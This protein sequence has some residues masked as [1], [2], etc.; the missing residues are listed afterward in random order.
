MVQM[1]DNS[2]LAITRVKFYLV[3]ENRNLF[4]V[5]PEAC[6]RGAL[7]YYLYDRV[8]DLRDWNQNI[9]ADKFE[10]L[11]ECL[12]GDF[13]DKKI[14]DR[15]ATLPRRG[16]LFCTNDLM[17]SDGV[18]LETTFFGKESA[19][20]SV[21]LEALQYI[22]TL[23]IGN[24]KLRF[25][26]NGVVSEQCDF[27]DKFVC[28]DVYDSEIRLIFVSP[29]ML[30]AKGG[31]FISTWNTEAFFRNL[32]QRINQICLLQGN[33]S[34]YDVESEHFKGL[35]GRVEV[36]SEVRYSSRLRTSS[37]QHKQLDCSGFKGR[38]FLK[39]VPEELFKLICMGEIVGVGKNTVF[40]GGRYKM[41][42]K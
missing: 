9:Q 1:S 32:A 23:G 17:R 33:V 7:G 2:S 31:V 39:N 35:Y 24:Q 21:L 40:G 42:K 38:V 3:V 15:S 6:I 34:L 8:R 12:L 26:V 41:A 5:F 4:S 20:V 22:G 27:I 36:V 10:N 30:R 14:A 16:M 37:R 18:F 29:T 13:P 28:D 25:F 11:Y 19:L